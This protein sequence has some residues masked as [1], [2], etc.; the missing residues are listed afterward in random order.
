MSRKPGYALKLGIFVTIGLALLI[1][2]IYFLGKQKNL[3]SDTFR[4]RVQF[5]TVSGL[6]TGNNVLFS[7]INAGIV[8][9]IE[10]ITD[11][12]VMVYLVIKKDMQRFIKTDAMAAIGSDGLMG[13]KVLTIYPGTPGGVPVSN[14]ALLVSKKRVEM[15]DLLSS[16]KTSVDN[17]GIITG[18][19]A[20]FTYKMN[21]GNGA[22][23]R[24]ISD[25]QF[26]GSLKATLGN[27]ETSSNE[28][29][30]FTTKM[31]SNKGAFG[32]MMND[33][34]FSNS[35]DSTMQ[36]LKTGT[37]GLSDNM[38]AAKSNFLLKPFFKR[39]AKAAAK[40]AAALKKLEL[41]EA[42]KAGVP[43][44]NAVDTIKN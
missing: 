41:L 20:Q 17:A 38:E 32:K 35:L 7:G 22:L 44:L 27:L 30:K 39:K 13:D 31:N 16:V 43:A 26:S 29:A 25:E 40:K 24:L 18:Q 37:K 10:L 33:E 21:N 9:N 11:T 42:K 15:D 19:L 6:K 5:T 3:F 4:L 28:F 34:K 1:A 36:N 23:S 2:T 14:D 8:D 12:T